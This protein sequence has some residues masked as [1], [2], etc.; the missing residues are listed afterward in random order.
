MDNQE[1][2]KKTDVAAINEKAP[3][4]D[5]ENQFAKLSKMIN[6][7]SRNVG[8][9]KLTSRL[10]SIEKLISLVVYTAG[11]IS[12]YSVNML[13]WAGRASMVIVNQEEKDMNIG[14]SKND[15]GVNCAVLD[16]ALGDSKMYKPL[17]KTAKK[18]LFWETLL[19]LF[20]ALIGQKWQ[21]ERDPH[22][23][24]DDQG[25]VAQLDQVERHYV[26]C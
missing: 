8:P 20:T 6:F 13:R 25:V 5:V 15:K 24:Q 22:Q 3:E 2:Q 12:G 21:F 26:V 11:H 4:N 19:K 23:L 14:T 1:R 17:L 10:V 18:I 9:I 16:A 7:E